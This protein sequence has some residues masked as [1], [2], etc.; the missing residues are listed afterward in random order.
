MIKTKIIA[1]IKQVTNSPYLGFVFLNTI[2]KLRELYCLSSINN[3]YSQ[4]IELIKVIKRCSKNNVQPLYNYLN[5]V[6]QRL[7]LQLQKTNDGYNITAHRDLLHYYFAMRISKEIVELKLKI[8]QT[9]KLKKS[10]AWIDIKSHSELIN[11]NFLPK[12]SS[13]DNRWLITLCEKY[14]FFEIKI[15]L[16]ESK[17][18]HKKI[19]CA[20]HNFCNV[21]KINNFNLGHNKLAIYIG[22]FQNEYNTS[23]YHTN[24]IY[25]MLKDFSA[26][27]HEWAHYL[28]NKAFIEEIDVIMEITKGNTFDYYHSQLT[29]LNTFIKPKHLKYYSLYRLLRKITI[30]TQTLKLTQ[31]YKLCKNYKTK[32]NKQYY[33]SRMTEIF[34]RLFE[35]YIASNNKNTIL[36]NNICFYENWEVYPKVN[37]VQ[38][39]YKDIRKFIKLITD[40]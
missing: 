31:Y 11:I 35:V 25:I 1:Q 6:E 9:Q 12:K 17:Y 37:I 23:V 38:P 14:R 34:A 29:C 33:W 18:S 19:E 36:N 2:D 4:Y 7:F 28:D 24:N 30:N 16:W 22:S 39:M 3:N 15:D 20:F 5:S 32:N 13:F 8:K 21:L 26:F 10:L 27:A 40:N